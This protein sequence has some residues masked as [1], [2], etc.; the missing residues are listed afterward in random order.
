V[1]FGRVEDLDYRRGTNAGREIYFNV[2]GQNTTGVNADF[3]RTKYGR[4]YRLLLDAN[5]PLRATLEVILDGDDKAGPAREF[6]NPDNVTVTQNYVYIAEDPNSYGDETHDA[7]IYQYNIATRALSIMMEVDHRRSEAK[8]NVGGVSAPGTWEFGGL[9][10][11]SDIVHRDNTYILS[12]QPHT[13]TG[14]RYAGVD[15]GTLR[16][17]ENQASQM[18]VITGLPR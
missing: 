1:K 5:D 4:V 16:P 14:T 8:Y 9:I 11:V 3:S 7:R 18:L 10:D 15:G 2:T 12:M 13:W 6:Q 17:T